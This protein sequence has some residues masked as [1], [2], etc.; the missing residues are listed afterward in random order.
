MKCPLAD[1][2]GKWNIECPLP[3][4]Q[5]KEKCQNCYFWRDGKCRYKR[6]MAE[7]LK[8]SMRGL[9][10]LGKRA[11]IK[12]K[13]KGYIDK[14][15]ARSY[16]EASLKYSN[17]RSKEQR[18]YWEISR[19]YD[20]EWGKASPEKRAELEWRMRQWAGFMETGLSPS[21]ADKKAKQLNYEFW[22]GM[23][24]EDENS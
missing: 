16:E 17:L 3:L 8:N 9:G 2:C 14:E 20:E 6:I 5:D 18:E 22:S 7:E 13:Q 10:V 11:A 24:Y 19:A 15:T 23:K 4:K 1:Y 12:A 21:E